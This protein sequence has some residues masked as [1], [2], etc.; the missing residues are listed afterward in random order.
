M[1]PVDSAQAVAAGALLVVLVRRYDISLAGKDA[2]ANAA[3]F[4]G[5]TGQLS[6][7]IV[8]AKLL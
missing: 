1:V 5:P 2:L 6:A 8:S 3:N 7:S 4:L